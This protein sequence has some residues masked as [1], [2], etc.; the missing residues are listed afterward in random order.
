VLQYWYVGATTRKIIIKSFCKSLSNQGALG[1]WFLFMQSCCLRKANLMSLRRFH[2]SKY[3]CLLLSRVN[4][5]KWKS[6]LTFRV[7]ALFFHQIKATNSQVYQAP[8]L[9]KTRIEFFLKTLYMWGR[10]WLYV[11]RLSSLGLKALSSHKSVK[12]LG[13]SHG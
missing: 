9:L 2:A 3:A 12:S 5:V 8:L 11:P 6:F 1:V 10:V 7:R 4:L 13:G